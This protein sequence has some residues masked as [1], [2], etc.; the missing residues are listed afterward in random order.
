M[1][2]LITLIITLVILWIGAHSGL[3]IALA[4]AALY[5]GYRVGDLDY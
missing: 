5:I 4:V 1:K 3:G 2:S